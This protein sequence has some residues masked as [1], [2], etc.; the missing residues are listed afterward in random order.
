MSERMPWLQVRHA[1]FPERNFLRI[2]IDGRNIF[3]G[4][5]YITFHPV[6]SVSNEFANG[7]PRRCV[8]PT[9]GTCE[10]VL[11]GSWQTPAT[12]VRGW[13]V[14]EINGKASCSSGS[15]SPP[16]GP[17][18]LEQ[19]FPCKPGQP[20]GKFLTHTASTFFLFLLSLQATTLPPRGCSWP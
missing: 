9:G 7:T 1:A 18:V 2:V 11:S 12:M 4:V 14:D 6:V 15:P 10:C 5:R 19:A 16:M 8:R 20:Y 13:I 3:L 17:R